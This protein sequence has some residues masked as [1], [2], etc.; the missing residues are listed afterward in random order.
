MGH[1]HDG[2]EIRVLIADD[3]EHILQAYREAFSDTDSTQQMRALDALAAE[4]V[5]HDF[6]ERATRCTSEIYSGETKRRP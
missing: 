4:L 1:H 2:N 3:D 5:A 6:K